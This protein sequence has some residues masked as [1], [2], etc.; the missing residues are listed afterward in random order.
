MLQEFL[1]I[2]CNFNFEEMNIDPKAP[3]KPDRDRF[4]LSK[5][6][7]APALYGALAPDLSFLNLT[8]TKK[9]IYSVILLWQLCRKCHTHCNRDTLSQRNFHVI[10]VDGHDFDALDAA[11]KEARETKGMPTA[12]IAKTVKGKD[13]PTAYDLQTLLLP[14]PVLPESHR[15]QEAYILG[16]PPIIAKTVKGKDVSFMENQASWHGAAPNDEQY[17]TAMADFKFIH[18]GIWGTDIGYTSVNL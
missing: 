15:H 14:R 11:F 8:V 3:D 10:D 7:V 6:H 1:H 17:E 2:L 5:G 12:I 4:V 13:D 16:N 18:N 9:R